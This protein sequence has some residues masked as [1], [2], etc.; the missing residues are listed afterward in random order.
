VSA[1]TRS[2]STRLIAPLR[3]CPELHAMSMSLR[4]PVWKQPVS[5]KI[6]SGVV[7]P[8]ES[9]ASAVI[10][11]KIEPVGY[12]LSSARSISGKLVLELMNFSS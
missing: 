4:A 3:S 6:V 5:W 8:E 7:T 10:G 12:A 1:E 9:A 11:L 2:A